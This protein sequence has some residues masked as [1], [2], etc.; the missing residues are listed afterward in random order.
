MPSATGNQRQTVIELQALDPPAYDQ[1][2]SKS[3]PLLISQGR[4]RPIRVGHSMSRHR[5][6]RSGVIRADATY[7]TITQDR[8][9]P[10]VEEENAVGLRAHRRLLG[11]A[12]ATNTG[13]GALTDR[14]LV[15]LRQARALVG[16]NTRDLDEEIT[17]RVLSDPRAWGRVGTEMAARGW[18]D[19]TEIAQRSFRP[20]QNGRLPQYLWYNPR[21]VFIARS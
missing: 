6:N 18:V 14:Q 7:D 19:D 10:V 3:F 21:R 1:A 4:G 16:L 11:P 13:H 2:S 12:H 15:E 9:R 5:T 20:E 17:R 8:Q